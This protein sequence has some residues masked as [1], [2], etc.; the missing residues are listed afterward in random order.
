MPFIFDSQINAKLVRQWTFVGDASREGHRSPITV[1]H[2]GSGVRSAVVFCRAE[3]HGG[4]TVV[5]FIYLGIVLA[6]FLATLGL[7]SAI[8]RMGTGS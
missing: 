3:T 6:L 2:Y 1:F 5:D 7:V 4:S 8:N